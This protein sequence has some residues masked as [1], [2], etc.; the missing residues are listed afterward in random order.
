MWCSPACRKRT[1]R[2][3]RALITNVDV[4]GATPEMRPQVTAWQ[5]E[6]AE[7]LFRVAT[8]RRHLVR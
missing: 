3:L 7:V 5:T 4:W 6:L 8:A 1:E 2:R